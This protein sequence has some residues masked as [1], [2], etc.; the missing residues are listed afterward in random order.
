MGHGA[1][2]A[3]LPRGLSCVGR[4]GTWRLARFFRPPV[5]SGWLRRCASKKPSAAMLRLAWGCN[6]RQPRPSSCPRPRS[7][8]RSWS[9]RSRR[10]RILGL[11]TPCAAAASLRALWTAQYSSGSGSPLGRSMSRHSGSRHASRQRSRCAARTRSRA[12]RELGFAFVPSRQAT[13]CPC[14]GPGCRASSLSDWGWCCGQAVACSAQAQSLGRTRPQPLE[15][16]GAKGSR[17]GGQTVTRPVT[18]TA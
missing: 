6:P 12:K 16:S 11:Q 5:S 3:G 13:V 17:P 1:A 9:S 7:C 14:S 10:Q 8:L 18:P 15:A 4:A 2:C